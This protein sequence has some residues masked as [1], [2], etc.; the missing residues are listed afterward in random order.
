L[1]FSENVLHDQEMEEEFAKKAGSSVEGILLQMA[2]ASSGLAP[3][4]VQS[5]TPSEVSLIR[6]ST[7]GL[8]L[9]I[10]KRLC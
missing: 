10:L 4:F 3:L 1:E 5:Y 8:E 9:R 7:L 6:I 2:V